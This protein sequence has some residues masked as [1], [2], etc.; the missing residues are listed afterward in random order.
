MLAHLFTLTLLVFTSAAFAQPKKPVITRPLEANRLM[1]ITYGSPSWNTNSATIDAAYLI[2]RDKATGKIVQINL[3][4]TEPD[5]S[6]FSGQFSV[7]IGESDKILPEIFIPPS[8]L[9]GTDKDNRKLYEQIQSNKL[10]RKP[11]IW[12]K[13][14]RG[15]ATLDV[16]D[17]REQAEAAL[18]AYQTQVTLAKAVT[19]AKVAKPLASVNA[20][21]VA[22]QLEK[23]VLLN[24]LASEAAK[25]ESERIRLEQIE[26]QKLEDRLREMRALDEKQKAERQARAI[27]KAGEA[28][29]LFEQAKFAEAEVKFK[30]SV[31]IDPEN[32]SY[33]FKYGVTLYR[34]EKYNDALV[35]FS[36]VKPDGKNDLERGYFIGLTHYR[37]KEL[38]AAMAQFDVVSKANDAIMSPSSEF[39]RGVILF[40]EEK[41]DVSKTSFEKVID[42]SNDPRLDDQA[43][44]YIE[45]IAN[46]LIIQKLRQNKFTLLGTVGAMYDSNVLLA[47]DNAPDQ[48]TSTDIAD[49]RL[50]TIA[51]LEYRPVYGDSHEFFL[52]GSA[53]LTNSLKN[54][55]APADP[56]LYTFSA[57]Y[58]YKGVLGKKGF[59]AT[60]K[61]GYEMLYMATGGSSTKTAALMSY[62]LYA[63]TTLVMTPT[64]FANYNAE[65]RGDDSKVASSLGPDDADAGKVSVRTN[66]TVFLD[67]SRKRALIGS[68]GYVLNTAK[69]DNRK[70]NRFEGGV[71]FAKPWLWDTTWNVGINFYKLAFPDSV[72]KRSDF[73]L[74]LASGLSKPV[75]EWLI[76]GLSGSYTKND[77]NVTAQEY[78]KYTILTTA[79]FLTNF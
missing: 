69:G 72:N 18:R 51:D 20:N 23:Q 65:Y 31:E 48:G 9:R 46:A 43:E 57:P 4:E 63:D 62:Y 77:S 52:R 28:M 41:Y 32:T 58:S 37:L 26:R 74:T 1:S 39:Y 49:F 64:W 5:S 47:P 10:P 79:T 40:A 44:T 30:E 42:T 53:G 75:K 24:Q 50:L 55:S 19:A 29:A 15:Q 12:K 66:Q 56:Y 59:K 17:T 60:L 21:V 35:V 45:R 11:V 27:V 38:D 16:Y 14:E 3:E 71:A 67:K 34:N 33:Y 78:S 2:M 73:N 25:R 36:L 22:A 61:P 76:W 13:N 7:N 6:Q 70:Y 54:S 68:L 8:N